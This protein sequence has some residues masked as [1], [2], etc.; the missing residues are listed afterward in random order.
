MTPAEQ[1]LSRLRCVH[2][3]DL[4][5]QEIIADLTYKSYAANRGYSPSISPERWAAI[6]GQEVYDMEARYQAEKGQADVN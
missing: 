3:R 2:C 5:V 1:A 6:Y 4:Q